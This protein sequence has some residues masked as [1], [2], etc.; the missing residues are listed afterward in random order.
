MGSAGAAEGVQARTL[1]RALEAV[2][3]L[4]AE[5]ARKRQQVIFFL[6]YDGTLSPIVPNPEEARVPPATRAVV[7]QL[8]RRFPTAIVTGRAVSKVKSFL[9]LD[10][11]MF[12][13]SHG[14]Y[15]DAPPLPPHSV[16]S[17]H[18]P[19]LAAAR[20]RLAVPAAA[21]RGAS[22]EDNNFSVSVHYRNVAPDALPPLRDAVESTVRDL[23]LRLHH[24]KMV[25]EIRPEF[26]WHKGRAVE[27][28]LRQLAMDDDRYFPI[29]LGDDV[30]DEDAFRSLRAHQGLG[31][32]VYD[33]DASQATS[34]TTHAALRLGS[35]DEV[36]LFL[37]FF[38]RNEALP[39]GKPT[40]VPAHTS[41]S[42]PDANGVAAAPG[43]TGAGAAASS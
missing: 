13:G 11:L 8:S 28:L 37:D 31:V 3:E 26:D 5:I 34:R 19:A 17:E 25:W 36:R 16:A 38:V 22:I 6:D 24:G 21:A 39:S 2:H 23:G 41:I 29:Y 7:E 43:G 42:T 30:T 33:P 15:I 14:F 1:P 12:A 18:L 35:P 27:Y 20:T 32:I 40:A 9:A 4:C 10:G